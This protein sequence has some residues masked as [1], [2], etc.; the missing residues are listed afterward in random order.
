MTSVDFRILGPVEARVDGELRMVPGLKPRALLAVLLVNRGR[1]VSS[2]AI[3]EAIWEGQG[4]GAYAASLQVYVSTLRRTLGSASGRQLVTRQPPGYRLIVD[5]DAVDLGRFEKSAAV[6]NELLRTRRYA[7]ASAK[8]RAALAQWSGPALADLSELRFAAEF[9]VAVEEE[10]LV[11][12]QARIEADLACGRVSEV[13]GELTTLTGQYPLREQ[14]WVQLITALYR[15]DRQADALDA[16]RRIRE[17]LG[18]ELGIDPSPALREL[19]HKILRQE[20]LPAAGAGE[21][22]QGLL[23]TVNATV[24]GSSFARLVL[25]SGQVVA[26]SSKGLRIGRMDDNDLVLDDVKVS[27][28][29]AHIVDVGTGFAITD[30]RSTNGT[31]VGSERVLDSRVLRHQDVIGIGSGQYIFEC[32][33]G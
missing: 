31:T 17:L 14:F 11:V 22:S 21:R 13:V 26:I 6:G 12:L 18:D 16:S 3:A 24:A 2:D 29:H 9:A 28:Y 27:R 25:S 20:L 10:R 1:V 23:Q 7:E 33:P 15:L 30:L 5:D 32:E 4:P 8:F 19:E